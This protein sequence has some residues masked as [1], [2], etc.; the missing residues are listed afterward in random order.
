MLAIQKYKNKEIAIYGMGI[1][2]RSAAKT[3]KNMG[4]KVFCWDDNKKVRR[5]IKNSNYIIEKFWL[6]KKSIKF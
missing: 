4:A 5:K 1:T 6:K 2:G 3:F